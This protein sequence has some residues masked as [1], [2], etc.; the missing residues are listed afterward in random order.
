MASLWPT[1]SVRN[2]LIQIF[3][4]NQMLSVVAGSPAAGILLPC[5]SSP[6]AG[7]DW[8]RARTSG[9]QEGLYAEENNDK[10]QSSRFGI[11]ID[12]RAEEIEAV[13]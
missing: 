6:E 10:R 1:V 12:I 8:G 2:H 3:S 7:L 9:E 5:L 4:D 13:W 11:G